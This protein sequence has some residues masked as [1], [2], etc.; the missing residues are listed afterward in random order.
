MYLR[1]Y[2]SQLSLS[3]LSERHQGPK[4]PKKN[5]KQP[6]DDSFSRLRLLLTQLLP[7]IFSAQPLR[8]YALQA[9]FWWNSTLR[10]KPSLRITTANFF[11]LCMLLRGQVNFKEK[12]VYPI[13]EMSSYFR[14]MQLVSNASTSASKGIVLPKI[15]ELKMWYF[16]TVA[17]QRGAWVGHGPPDFSLAPQYCA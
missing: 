16:H 14:I 2:F 7:M 10:K 1:I 8:P 3:F 6:K 5:F 12:F 11:I 9:C 4:L 15:D 13:L 17:V